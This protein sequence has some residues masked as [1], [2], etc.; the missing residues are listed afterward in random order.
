MLIFYLVSGC[1]VISC[2]GIHVSFQQYY[3]SSSSAFPGVSVGFTI[4]GE[5]FVY[6]TISNPTIEVV[7][8]NAG[9]GFVA[10]IHPSR[11]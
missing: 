7:T 5:I 9:C 4:F 6:V 3:T 11:T 8:L 1:G 10:C 2:A